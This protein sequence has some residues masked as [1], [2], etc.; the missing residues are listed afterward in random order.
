MILMVTVRCENINPMYWAWV[1][2]Y[3]RKRQIERCKAL[4]MIIEEHMKFTK[5]E[6]ERSLEE[7]SIAKK[8][9]K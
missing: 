7:G 4:E 5:R 8:K 1:A 3:A 9:K 6:Y 2:E